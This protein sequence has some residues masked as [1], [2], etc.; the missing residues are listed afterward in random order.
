MKNLNI[1][2]NGPAPEEH[3]P[4]FLTTLFVGLAEEIEPGATSGHIHSM[5]LDGT[6]ETFDWSAK[7]ED[8][9]P[10]DLAL[11]REARD[12]AVFSDLPKSVKEALF[13]VIDENDGL[14]PCEPP[15]SSA[16]AL[17]QPPAEPGP[18]FH[19]TIAGRHGSGKSALAQLI[20]HSLVEAGINSV[21][22]LNEDTLPDHLAATRLQRLASLVGKNPQIT[23]D[24]VQLRREGAF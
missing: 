10:G 11:L 6:L 12:F 9:I 19:I 18:E 24:M 15:T 21:K 22:V 7:V 20:G 8:K 4:D 1:T 14:W 13:R 16:P 3:D 17:E 2:I 23:L 5:K